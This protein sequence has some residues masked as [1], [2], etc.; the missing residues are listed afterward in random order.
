MKREWRLAALALIGLVVAGCSTA[1]TTL[2][3]ADKSNGQVIYRISEEKA[4]T[5]A[6]DA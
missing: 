2:V 5:I 6:L 3:R 1:S 4:F